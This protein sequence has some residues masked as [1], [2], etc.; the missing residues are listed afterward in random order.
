MKTSTAILATL[1]STAAFA[2][3][4]KPVDFHIAPAHRRGHIP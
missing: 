3:D 4:S 2:Q 1:L